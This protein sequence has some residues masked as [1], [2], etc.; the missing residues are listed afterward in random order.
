MKCW[1]KYWKIKRYEGPMVRDPCRDIWEAALL[2]APK[3]L[4]A[5]AKNFVSW[6]PPPKICLRGE[7]QFI[8]FRVGKNF[9]SVPVPVFQP[10][11]KLRTLSSWVIPDFYR[12]LLM[13]AT[14]KK[15]FEWRRFRILR[16][17]TVLGGVMFAWPDDPLNNRV[18]NAWS[19]IF[20]KK[21]QIFP[22]KK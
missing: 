4:K 10:E 5:S 2:G 8:N 3:I 15:F 22:T 19:R 17:P 7:T 9:S 11:P 21:C 13:R 20:R 16:A 12:S 14:E 1:R 18:A 6:Y